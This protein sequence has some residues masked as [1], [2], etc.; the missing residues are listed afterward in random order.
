MTP[1]RTLP[2]ASPW[3]VL[4][5]YTPER[6]DLHKILFQREHLL[7]TAGI[8]GGSYLGSQLAQSPVRTRLVRVKCLESQVI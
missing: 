6:P 5:W 8:H 1:H 4:R 3:T 2:S 7:N